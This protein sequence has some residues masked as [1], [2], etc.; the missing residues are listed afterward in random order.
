MRA[1]LEFYQASPQGPAVG[2]GCLLCNTAIELGP[3]DPSGAG[4]VQ[5][6]FENLSS[7][8]RAA[9]EGA[10]ERGE[11][12]PGVE[13]AEV[14]QFFTTSVLGMFVMLRAQAPA[15]AVSQAARVAI[16]HLEGLRA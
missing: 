12:K 10:R 14:A 11:L 13:P 4:H 1:L 16:D 3:A 15:A 6:Y 2:R 7:A 9:L 5:R 8:F